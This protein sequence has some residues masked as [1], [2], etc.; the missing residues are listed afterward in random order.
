MR[1]G[2]LRFFFFFLRVK[3]NK[4][5]KSIWLFQREFLHTAY[6]DDTTFFL[7]DENS[8]SLLI[9]IVNKFL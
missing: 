9:Q 2:D 5:I 1:Q 6:A 7:K 8:V 3:Q 4:D